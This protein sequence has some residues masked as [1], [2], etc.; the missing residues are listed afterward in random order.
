MHGGGNVTSLFRR[1]AIPR[2]GQ[3]MGGRTCSSV[4][5][6]SIALEQDLGVLV[7]LLSNFHFKRLFAEAPQGNLIMTNR[8]G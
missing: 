2:L 1:N 5:P 3:A 4:Q 7:D 8:G 6:Q